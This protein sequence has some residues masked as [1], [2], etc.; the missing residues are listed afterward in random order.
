MF[1]QL[2]LVLIRFSKNQILFEK[3]NL[4]HKILSDLNFCCRE[5]ASVDLLCLSTLRPLFICC[6]QGFS[7][8][9]CLNC[10]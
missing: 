8:L 2:Y 1:G 7:K 3:D 6:R 4:A 5:T 9:T 10:S